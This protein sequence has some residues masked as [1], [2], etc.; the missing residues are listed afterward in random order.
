MKT[1]DRN[2]KSGAQGELTIV[3]LDALTATERAGLSVPKKDREAVRV[4]GAL[5]VGHSET[6]HHHVVTSP[7]ARLLET[8]NPLVCLL[9]LEAPASLDHLRSH[10]T[11]E[12]WSLPAG[13]YLITRQ[14]EKGPLGWQRVED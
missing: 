7:D 11:H 9:R 14:R 1:W 8:I 4:N 3:R 10:D 6:G 2:R 5:V 12:S 13:D